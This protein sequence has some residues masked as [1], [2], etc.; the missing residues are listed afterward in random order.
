MS[1]VA[2]EK[3]KPKEALVLAD[4]AELKAAEE[5]QEEFPELEGVAEELV[6][7]LVDFSM[8]V[9]AEVE[10]RKNAVETMGIDLQKSSANQSAMLKEPIRILAE[11]GQDGGEVADALVNLKMEVEKLDPAKFDFEAGWLS[12]LLGLIPLIGT[13]TKRYFSRYEAAETIIE[14]V[15]NSLKEGQAQLQRDNKTLT[16]DQSEMRALTIKLKKMVKLA[17]LIDEKL[18]Y[19]LDRE[20][21]DTA[22]KEFILQELLFPLRQRIMDLQQ[23]L[24]VNQ[25]GVLA[26]EL[27]IRNNKELVRGVDRAI[28]VTVTAL[29]VAVVVAMAL[30]HQ[31]IVLNKIN[32]LNSTTDNLIAGTASRLKTQGVEIQK[33]A[34][35][36]QLNM[37]HLKSA[38]ADI[39]GAMEAIATFRT[40]A[41]PVMAT[42]ILEMDKLTGAA[43]AAIEKMEKGNQSKPSI[44][45][46][47][48]VLPEG[49]VQKTL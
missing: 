20:I 37:E 33:Q 22:K 3:P 4:P 49:P 31:K 48:Q 10:D 36:T 27:I 25:Q 47:E 21:T 2:M 6:S 35:S 1:S 46:D 26:M 13:P 7:R 8:T 5:A 24:A 38:F 29:E 42:T 30:A 41:L 39:N 11:K 32:A 15:I 19:K 28:N 9:P 16:R 14:A 45:I 17:Q 43:E 44:V 12:R 40:D 34:S 18:Q 23:Q